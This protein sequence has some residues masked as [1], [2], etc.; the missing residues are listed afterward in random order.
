M[1]FENQKCFVVALCFLSLHHR[2]Y[3]SP[4]FIITITKNLIFDCDRIQEDRESDARVLKVVRIA[5]ENHIVVQVAQLGNGTSIL[6]FAR[7]INVCSPFSK[8]STT[9]SIS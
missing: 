4:F 6:H 5:Q 7:G 1:S 8:L 2:F 3:D 9:R